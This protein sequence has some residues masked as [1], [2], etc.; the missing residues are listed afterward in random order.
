MK[1]GIV[2]IGKLGLPKG[3]VFSSRGMSVVG[4]DVNS[5]RIREVK[6]NKAT[7]EPDVNRFWKAFSFPVSCDYRALK[8]C[9][10]VFVVAQTPSLPSGKF[11]LSYVSDAVTEVNK[12]N[13][14]CLVAVSSTVNVGDCDKLRWVH[15]RIAYNPSFI[16]QG[17]IIQDFEKPPYVL[18]GGDPEDLDVLEVVWRHIHNSF[19]SR[20]SLVEAEVVKLAQNVAFTLDMTLANAIGDVCE[21]F[22]VDSNVV[23]DRIYAVRRKY[24]S[25]L[26]FGGPCFTRDVNCF[27]RTCREVHAELGVALAGVIDDINERVTI[28]KYAERIMSFDK[29]KIG[30]LGLAFKSGVPYVYESQAIKVIRLL[31]RY[32]NRFRFYVYDRLAMDEARKVLQ[33]VVFCESVDEVLGHAEVVF[34]GTKECCSLAKSTGKPCVDPWHPP[35]LS[36]DK[37]VEVKAYV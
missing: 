32:D 19:V 33:D 2:G 36:V 21:K 7:Y 1:L 27:E 8:G 25:G 6:S 28:R 23:L 20:M 26:G 34:V 10:V 11:D 5:E 4:V 3:L 12:V 31:Q 29:L 30:V 22:S 16:K 17:S 13:P 15:P 35:V 37:K 24:R 14:S 9:T 18:M